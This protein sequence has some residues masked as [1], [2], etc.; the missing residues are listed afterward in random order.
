MKGFPT[1][2]FFLSFLSVEAFAQSTS[3][4]QVGPLAYEHLNHSAAHTSFLLGVPASYQPIVV[5]AHTSRTTV[6][7]IGHVGTS[8]TP[9]RLWPYFP[10]YTT[11]PKSLGSGPF[12]YRT[13]DHS[14][15]CSSGVSEPFQIARCIRFLGFDRPA[16]NRF[17]NVVVHVMRH[18]SWQEA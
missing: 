16:L 13:F 17:Q 2:I 6:S 15:Q 3:F 12:A 8:S 4:Q 11:P 9:S 5:D 14:T 18:Y 1:T 7:L 10:T